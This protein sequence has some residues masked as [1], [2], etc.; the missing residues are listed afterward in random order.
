MPEQYQPDHYYALLIQGKW[1]CA[2]DCLRSFAD[3]APLLEAQLA[4]RR[5][6][7]PPGDGPLRRYLMAYMEYY[8]DVFLLETDPEAAEAALLARILTLFP[9]KSTATV[10]EAEKT[11]LSPAFSAQGYRFLGGKTAGFFGP[12]VWSRTED[13]EYEVELP[14]GAA[15]HPVRL[16]SGFL[17]KSW[18]DCISL[19]QLS[20]GGWTDEGGV[21]CCIRDSYDP[22]SEAFRVSLLNHE[23]QH[24][25]DLARYPGISQEKLEYRAKLVEL[26]Y[27]SERTLLPEFLTEAVD[28]NPANGHAMAAARL[29]RE[30]SA[31]PVPVD[32]IPCVQEAARQLFQQSCCEL[33]A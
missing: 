8:R 28:S 7:A 10:S 11:L 22:E 13:A 21:I 6:M 33:S 19:G 27:S 26:I 4:F 3:A 30:F 32:S 24:A 18:L 29:K 16:L 12:Y 31:L 17:T 23:A 5:S 15:R 14:E 2:I 25:R 20:T 9:G 1:N